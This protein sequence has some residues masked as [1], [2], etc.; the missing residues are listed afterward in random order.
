[1]SIGALPNHK[2]QERDPK[3]GRIQREHN[4][5]IIGGPQVCARSS[6]RT[7]PEG[8]KITTDAEVWRQLVDLKSQFVIYTLSFIVLG[9]YCICLH[10][11]CSFGGTSFP[12]RR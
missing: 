10:R 8:V 3:K 2:T 11:S 4:G 6:W 1:M 5:H 9:T 12:I 7:H